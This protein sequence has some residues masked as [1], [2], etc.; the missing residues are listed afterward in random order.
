MLCTLQFPNYETAKAAAT[1][2]GFWDTEADALRT[3]G[4]SQDA[5][6]STFGW[7]IDEI[8]A[9]PVIIPG[10]YDD[11]GN[12]ITPAVRLMGYFVNFTGELL[13]GVAA[14]LAPGGY[15]CAGRVFAGTAPAP[16]EVEGTAERHTLRFIGNAAAKAALQPLSLWKEEAPE[17]PVPFAT[18]NG[19]GL[20]IQE[21][22]TNPNG[23]AGYYMNTLGPLPSALTPYIVPY[24]S[25]GEGG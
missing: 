4:Q 5:D 18:V 9:D 11:E 19:G 14:F 2:L 23:L 13:P 1:A 25:A 17:G 15:G 20:S 3:S 12:E 7:A 6:G 21:I 22:G 24:G 10:E 8:G 16:H